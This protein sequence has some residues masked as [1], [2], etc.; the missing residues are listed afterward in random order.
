MGFLSTTFDKIASIIG[1]LL[2]QQIN[3][4]T[5][6]STGCLHAKAGD[7]AAKEGHDCQ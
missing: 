4:L 5:K 1:A 3:P 2:A 7:L 6:R